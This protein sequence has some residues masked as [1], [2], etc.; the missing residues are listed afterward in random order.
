MKKIA[1]IINDMR[2]GGAE[3]VLAN[4]TMGFPK[5]WEIDI[6]LSDARNI[7]Y[8]YRGN[9]ID[10]GI[11]RDKIAHSFFYFLWVL[12]KRCRMLRILKKEKKYDVCIGFAD[13]AS[14]ANILSGKKYCKIVSTVHLALT[15]AKSLP[16][17]KYIVCPL[18]KLLYNQ[19]D[20]V[21]TVSKGI[22]L[23]LLRNYGIKAHKLRTI[24]NGCDLETIKQ[25]I[26]KPLNEKENKWV[27]GD[28]VIATM[29]RLDMQKAQWHLIRAFAKVLARIPNAKL[30]ILGI[31]QQEVYLRKLVSELSLEEQVVFCGFQSNPFK[32][33]AQSNLFVFPSLFEGF[34]NAIIEAM[35]CGLPAI[36]TDFNTGARELLAPKTSIDNKVIDTIEFAEYGILSPVC[37]GKQYTSVEKLTEQ[38]NLLA[39]A[40]IDLWNDKDKYNKYRNIAKKRAEEFSLEK[41]VQ[42]WQDFICDIG[43]TC[44]I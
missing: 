16:E 6:I 1:F 22:E 33:L 15:E 19:S 25:K 34:S 37:D 42:E 38:E 8:E 27:E 7:D 14:V 20:K 18:V 36:A 21:I 12:W 3:R 17:Y 41:M 39:R 11:Y 29:G 26:N 40:I 30:L 44:E 4:L 5:D 24:Y 2:I 35:Y 32:I 43:E 31:G 13:S 23:D 9:V 28:F 10:L